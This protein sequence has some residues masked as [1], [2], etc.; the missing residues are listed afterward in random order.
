MFTPIDGNTKIQDGKKY[1]LV[2]DIRLAFTPSN[3]ER[4]INSIRNADKFVHSLPSAAQFNYKY[5]RLGKVYTEG[6]NFDSTKK[7]FKVFVEFVG[8][9]PNVEL[10]N[11]SN[12]IAADPDFILPALA[13]PEVL[14]IGGVI[15]A[16]I[17]VATLGFVVISKSFEE[18]IAKPVFSPI[19]IVIAAIV[20]FVII[21]KRG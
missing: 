12:R 10:P 6:G 13:L 18:H 4:I 19:G 1:R 5:M 9:V 20:A 2:L 21:K 15:V 3:V 16:I 17:G 14:A 11:L 8:V 7:Q